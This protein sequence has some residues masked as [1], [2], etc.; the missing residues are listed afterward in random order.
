MGAYF[1]TFLVVMI[2][3]A[4]LSQD[5]FIFTL[6]Y[7][8]AGAY[9]L[10]NWWNNRVLRSIS[11]KRI[12]TDHAFPGET[13]PVLLELENNSRLPA[14]WFQIQE[15]VPLEIAT[16]KSIQKIVTFPG[17]GKV[18]L[19]YRLSPKRRGYYKVGPVWY[20]SGDLLGL[21]NIKEMEGGPHF[22]TVYPKVFPISSAR[23][24]SRSPLGDLKHERPIFEDPSR[25]IGK[26]E[27]RSG[28]SLRRIDWKASASIGKLQV[29][30]FEPS[31]ALE[32]ILLLNLNPD[33]YQLKTRFFAMEMAISIAASLANWIM[34]KK[35]AVGLVTNGIDILGNE[36]APQPLPPR[37]GRVHLIR[38]LET[39]ARIQITGKEPLLSLLH[40][41]RF[42]LSWGTTL[43]II[44]GQV[45]KAMFDEL[46][47]AKRT[48]IDIVLILCG[49]VVGLSDIRRRAEYYKIPIYYFYDERD[50]DAWRN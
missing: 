47:A 32:T 25:P 43:I 13:I 3:L 38:M 22:L 35:Q 30:L 18:R 10:G 23:I 42:S 20:S 1:I 24:L 16:T 4:S 19:D 37:K 21:I 49:E 36:T 34:G 26:R 28:D 14:V 2:V 15:L 48:G 29:K 33:E 6:V 5:A 41:N 11:F 44:T 9:L 39:L 17:R 12:F 27:Y 50:L 45:D 40:H 46:F 7:L 8:F 31:I